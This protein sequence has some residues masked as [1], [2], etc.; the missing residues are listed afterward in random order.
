MIHT[1]AAVA[2]LAEATLAARQYAI[3][4]LKTPPSDNVDDFL[5]RDDVGFEPVCFLIGAVSNW[6]FRNNLVEPDGLWCSSIAITEPRSKTIKRTYV[7]PLGGR[8][9]FT[10]AFHSSEPLKRYNW[11]QNGNENH[12]P[13]MECGARFGAMTNWP[14]FLIR[15]AL[16]FSRQHVLVI[17]KGAHLLGKAWYHGKFIPRISPI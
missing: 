9:F 5:T 12:V 6:T 17:Y 4:R 1:C 11:I 15:Q 10:P 13:L 8:V 7:S 2:A 16:K 14:R 3:A